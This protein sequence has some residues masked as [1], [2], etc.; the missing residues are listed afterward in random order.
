MDALIALCADKIGKHCNITAMRIGNKYL[1]EAVA[2][3]F[4]AKLFEN[5]KQGVWIYSD[6]A[7]K[8]LSVF[9]KTDIELQ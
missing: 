8:M 1:I 4:I 2:C 9:F 3:Y 6:T 5:K 7:G